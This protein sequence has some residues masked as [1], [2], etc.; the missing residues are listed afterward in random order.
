MSSANCCLY[1]VNFLTV[2]Y[3]VKLEVGK[4]CNGFEREVP[5]AGGPAV[6]IAEFSGVY[7]VQAG[8]D[9][10]H[11][12]PCVGAVKCRPGC[13]A[14][15]Y[16]PLSKMYGWSRFFSVVVQVIAYFLFFGFI[17]LAQFELRSA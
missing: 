10:R 4:A 13:D 9:G 8:E 12:C 3:L 15:G 6:G 1:I 14:G 7:H 17:F 11:G 5:F 2:I 16:C